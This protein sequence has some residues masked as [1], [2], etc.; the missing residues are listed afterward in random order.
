MAWVQVPISP[1]THSDDFEH[2]IPSLCASVF[3]SIKDKQIE[4]HNGALAEWN[5]ILPV[6]LRY[7]LAHSKGLTGFPGSS[8][9]KNPPANAGAVGSIP[10]SERSPREGNGNPLQYSCWETPWTEEP[11]RLQFMGLQR[12]GYDLVTKQQP[13]CLID[14]YPDYYCGRTCLNLSFLTSRSGIGGQ[15]GSAPQHLNKLQSFRQEIL[16]VEFQNFQ[17]LWNTW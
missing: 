7:C 12:V 2:V 1:W 17:Q 15:R 14:V 5:K 13:K 9:V 16:Y 3:K 11:G 6:R 10:E 8:V 4:L